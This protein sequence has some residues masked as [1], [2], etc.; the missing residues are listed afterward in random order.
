MPKQPAS[1]GRI[2]ANQILFPRER[3]RINGPFPL[4]FLGVTA[5]SH[6]CH[7]ADKT[8][9]SLYGILLPQSV[10]RSANS[11]PARPAPTASHQDENPMADSSP[12]S[13]S[14]REGAL[15]ALDIFLHKK[16]LRTFGKKRAS[17]IKRGSF[18]LSESLRR[19]ILL[20]SFASDISLLVFPYS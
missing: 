14:T 4:L 19:F 1:A 13:I 2:L 5:Y 17:L 16:Q 9:L 12:N 11:Q 6:V 10:V 20:N 15:Q 18:L 3:G 8:F 7:L